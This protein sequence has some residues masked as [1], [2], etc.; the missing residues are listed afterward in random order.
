MGKQ[1]AKKKVATQLLTPIPRAKVLS[2]NIASVGYDVAL[3]VLEVEFHGG[4][5]YRY[6]GVPASVH[7]NLVTATSVG[8][9]FHTDIRD[10]YPTTRIDANAKG[11]KANG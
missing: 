2:S 3:K 6:S 8:S 5:I 9:F 4:R 10:R 7:K 1:P 11:P